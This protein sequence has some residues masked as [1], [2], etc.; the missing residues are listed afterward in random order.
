MY[1]TSYDLDESSIW[2]SG[3]DGFSPSKI[4]TGLKDPRGIV[5]DFK[6]SRL[7]WAERGTKRI[8]SS[9]LEGSNVRTILQNLASPIGIAVIGGN[10]FW[11]NSDDNTLQSSAGQ[12]TK[13][14]THHT[15]TSGIRY[16]TVVPD[17]ECPT[18]DRITAKDRSAP[19]F[20]SS[21]PFPTSA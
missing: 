9:S 4:V 6:T 18:I 7:Y 15:D 16:L 21:P 5:T 13:I 17:V 14:H 8:Q 19:V 20:V 3:M 12:G 2:K 1:W 10:I 11:G